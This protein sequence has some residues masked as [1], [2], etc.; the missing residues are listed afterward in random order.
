MYVF[1]HSCLTYY[2][3]YNQIKMP[4][5]YTLYIYISRILLV[6]QIFIDSST[7]N[8]SI[9]SESRRGYIFQSPKN[10]KNME[11]MEDKNRNNYVSLNQ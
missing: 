5:F 8:F 11:D 2:I 9:Y 10:D 6:T 1:V 3:Y 7:M 4:F